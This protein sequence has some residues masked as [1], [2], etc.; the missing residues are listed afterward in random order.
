MAYKMLTREQKRSLLMCV[1]HPY[2][3]AVAYETYP[4]IK[5]GVC[6]YCLNML[7]APTEAEYDVRQYLNQLKVSLY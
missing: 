4:T 2:I 5:G 1:K 3:L 7:T 6:A